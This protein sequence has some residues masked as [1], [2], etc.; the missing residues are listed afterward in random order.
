MV[1]VLIKSCLCVWRAVCEN[2]RGVSRCAWL[3]YVVGDATQP[4]S[5]G[6]LDVGE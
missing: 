3:R 5:P 1:N 4:E 2:Q 6:E